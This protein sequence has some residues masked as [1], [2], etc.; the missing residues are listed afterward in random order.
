MIDSE[1]VLAWLLARSEVRGD[2][3]IWTKGRSAGGYGYASYDGRQW[4]VHR[5]AWVARYGLIPSETPFVLH[6]CDTPPCWADDHLFLGTHADNMADMVAK[7]RVRAPRGERH[8]RAKLTE[9]DV[10]QIRAST[11][12]TRAAGARF[13][14][15]H[16]V[17]ASI[18]HG[19][20]WVS[21]S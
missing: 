12:S 14:V 1:L 10:R 5:L 4:G 2:C 9:A 16:S 21:N 17:I 20:I 13:G 11:E 7:G 18:R 6:R 8:G 19:R 15:S 3:L